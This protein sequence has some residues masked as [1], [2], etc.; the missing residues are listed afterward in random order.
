MIPP[1]VRLPATELTEGSIE[2]LADL[3]ATL[4]IGR[5][6][7]VGDQLDRDGDALDAFVI[8]AALAARSSAT[9][10]GV[11]SD[12]T[13]GRAAS[14][15]ARE[16]TALEL[17]G[18]CEVLLL[19][20]P[21]ASCRDAAVVIGSLFTPGVHTVTTPTAAIVA[22]RNLPQPS[23]PGGPAVLWREGGS[24]LGLQDGEPA[25]CGRVVDVALDVAAKAATPLPTP[26]PGVLLVVAAP[27]HAPMALAAA[28]AP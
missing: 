9:H 10:L 28:L 23:L 1:L 15:I 27:R 8:A 3:V 26:E 25:D 21:P 6:V 7:L 14:I 19:E 11:A 20:G 18:G 12:V 17:L 2:A 4:G 24:L 22:A 5:T 16:A 13:G